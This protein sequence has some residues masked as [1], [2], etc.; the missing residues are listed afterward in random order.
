MKLHK[1]SLC[2]GPEGFN[3]VNMAFVVAELIVP[4]VYSIMFLISQVHQAMVASPLIRVNNAVW[5]Y[6]T[7][8]NGL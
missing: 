1:S 6:F 2:K 4:M 8:N 3:A 7:A 5:S